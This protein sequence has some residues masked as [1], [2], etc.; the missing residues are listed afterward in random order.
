[1]SQAVVAGAAVDDAAGSRDARLEGRWPL[2]L[3]RVELFVQAPQQR[4]Q[5]RGGIHDDTE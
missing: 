5:F 2:R 4:Y 3:E 1:M